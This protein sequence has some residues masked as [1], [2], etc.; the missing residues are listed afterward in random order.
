MLFNCKKSV[1][2]PKK[3][4]TQPENKCQYPNGHNEQN[5]LALV[6]TLQA[7]NAMLKSNNTRQEI[8]IQEAIQ[9]EKHYLRTIN[10]QKSALQ[11]KNDQIESLSQEVYWHQQV[12][13][14]TS[15]IDHEKICFGAYFDDMIMQNI[16]EDGSRYFSRA[17]IAKR[18]GDKGTGNKG[19]SFSPIHSKMEK[20]GIIKKAKPEPQKGDK[21]KQNHY[22]I[23]P[24]DF[25]AHPEL[26]ALDD[27]SKWGGKHA[28]HNG[29][30]GICTPVVFYNCQKCDKIVSIEEVYFLAEDEVESRQ[31][32]EE[33]LPSMEALE[34]Y[35]V[36]ALLSDMPREID[37]SET[38]SF[39]DAMTVASRVSRKQR[40]ALVPGSPL[41]KKEM[42][43]APYDTRG[44]PHDSS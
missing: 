8:I 19:Q 13:A 18:M 43:I 9:K 44:S 40:Y 20:Y 29:C 24:Y 25:F 38:K 32:F 42:E 5:L 31:K 26:L 33:N 36:T 4:I 14:N 15:L 12:R 11:A 7:E 41:L 6:E 23:I 39:H 28:I 27:H 17:S 16:R 2:K 34:D 22:D 21:T 35:E 10:T 1:C 37:T 3:M 30:G